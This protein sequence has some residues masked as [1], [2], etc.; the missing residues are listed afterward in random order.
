MENIIA[1]TL[2]SQ[3]DNYLDLVKSNSFNSEQLRFIKQGIDFTL[4]SSKELVRIIIEDYANLI[5]EK[6]FHN[7]PEDLNNYI[8]D[9]IDNEI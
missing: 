8:K 2:K 7:Q 1:I 5:L 4:N 9:I 6:G 3:I